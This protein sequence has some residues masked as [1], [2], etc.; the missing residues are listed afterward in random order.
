[1]TLRDLSGMPLKRMH[2]WVAMAHSPCVTREYDCCYESSAYV[3]SLR[4]RLKRYIAA[5]QSMTPFGVPLVALCAFMA[6]HALTQ[7]ELEALLSLLWKK[8][9]I[10]QPEQ[11]YYAVVSLHTNE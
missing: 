4:R 8:G 7:R 1:M 9:E 11:H 5:R 10:L 2:R 3:L 6:Q